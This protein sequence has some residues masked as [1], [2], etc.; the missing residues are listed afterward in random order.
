MKINWVMV[1]PLVLSLGLLGMAAVRVITTPDAPV[2]RSTMT[3]LP[4]TIEG[5]PAPGLGLLDAMD[6]FEI[7]RDQ[8]LRGNGLVIVNFWASWCVPCRAEHPILTAL[9][10]AGTPLFGINYRDTPE[11]ARA[12]L[13]ELGNPFDRLG[14]DPDAR[15]GR[16]WELSALP[17]T[18]FINDDGAVVLHFRGPLVRRNLRTQVI[19]ALAAAGYDLPGAAAIA[20]D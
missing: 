12:F 9:A 10:E 17:E 13:T 6:Q 19:P 14:A 15:V 3:T 18:F 8:D 5:R 4:A 11:A 16:D 7:P 1:A 20:A 2:A